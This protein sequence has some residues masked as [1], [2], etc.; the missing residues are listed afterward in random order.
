MDGKQACSGCL[1]NNQF[2]NGSILDFPPTSKGY[3]IGC[4]SARYSSFCSSQQIHGFAQAV[5]VD[6][7]SLFTCRL[8]W[9]Y[10]FL[11]RHILAP[12]QRISFLILAVLPQCIHERPQH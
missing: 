10:T 7:F 5:L 6:S 8:Q 2:R 9:R 12:D 1:E 4:H 3:R 11:A